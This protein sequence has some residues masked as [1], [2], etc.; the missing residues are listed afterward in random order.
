MK[1]T[2][3]YKYGAYLFNFTFRFLFGLKIKGLSNIPEE[4]RVIIAPNHLS[5]YDPPLVG[6]CVLFRPI[7][8][9][10]KK[11][12]FVNKF[13]RWI[14]GKVNA[15]PVNTDRPKVRTMKKFVEF[16]ENENAVMV[17]PEGTRSKTGKFLRAKPGVGYLA[18]K[19]DSPVIP[20]LIRGTE[21]SM[22][23]HFLRISPLEVVFGEPI[24]PDSDRVSTTEALRLSKKVLNKVKEMAE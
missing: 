16:L 12:L 23:E 19:A 11:G 1:A 17:F 8:F 2:I 9:L 10:A 15:I 5:N 18:L 3:A 7:Y 6:C 24:Y 21:R 22:F 4:G 20:V 14:L 13:S